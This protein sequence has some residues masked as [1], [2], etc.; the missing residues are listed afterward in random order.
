MLEE[1]SS[2]VG[3]DDRS[4]EDPELDEE[5]ELVLE[6]LESLLPLPGSSEFA[7]VFSSFLKMGAPPDLSLRWT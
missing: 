6:S 3:R 4:S 2:D 5:L 7:F 1:L